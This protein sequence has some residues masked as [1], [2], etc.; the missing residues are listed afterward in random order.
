V[1]DLPLPPRRASLRPSL[2]APRPRLRS[3]TRASADGLA[4]LG[5]LLLDI[6]VV[7]DEPLQRGT[8]VPGTVRFR[9]GGSAAN[10]AR[11]FSRL[12]GR[13]TFIGAIGAD[14]MGRRLVSSLRVSG[15][16]VHAVATPAPTGRLVA[17]VERGG[18]DRSF[19][20][21]RGATDA[22]TPRDVQPAWFRGIG[23]LHLP[24]YS[25]FNYPLG[26]AAA[27]A[28]DLAHG[29]GVLI[30]VDLASRGPLLSAGR[31]L[32]W[33]R[34]EAVA[35][36]VILAN[37]PEAIALT[38]QA[39][40]PRLLD[41]APVVV[42]KEGSEGCRVLWREPGS[43]HT[44]DQTVATT[45]ITASDTTGAGDAFAAGFLQVLLAAG[46]AAA[47][48][49]GATALRRAALAGHAAAAQLLRGP[50]PEL[51]I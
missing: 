33:S 48:A 30:S 16:T 40:P 8:D 50:R 34:I 12:G 44:A 21:E 18:G 23:A 6:V 4:A 22:L 27:R 47:S 3:S 41:L 28:V 1:P 39:D 43:G 15:V 19:L 20:T 42:I 38:G 9:Q 35:P 51:V 17:I 29:R 5:D 26:A 31:R 10:V 24:G 7:G 14:S 45:P 32:I 37:A 49:W 36:H 13:A 25:L 46:G 11:T 2:A